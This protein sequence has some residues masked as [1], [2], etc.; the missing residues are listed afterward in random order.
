MKI[1][2]DSFENIHLLQNNFWSIW[3]MATFFAFY[4]EISARKDDFYQ[5]YLRRI[6]VKM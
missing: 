2:I 4:G 5:G 1:K 3:V 6:E